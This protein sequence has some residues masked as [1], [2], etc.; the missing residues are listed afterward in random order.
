[1]HKLRVLVP[2]I[3]LSALGV[4]CTSARPD[5]RAQVTAPAATAVTGKVVS[6][7]T[8]SVEV[9]T[10]G[11]HETLGLSA[12]TRGRE[13]LLVG[14]QLTFAVEHDAGRGATVARIT[15]SPSPPHR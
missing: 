1:M 15:A 6:F 8:S 9:E 3:A 10:P 5:A 13:L 12:A 14:A 7:T 4:A 2:A 11:G